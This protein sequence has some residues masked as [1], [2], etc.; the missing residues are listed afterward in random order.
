MMNEPVTRNASIGP[1][2]RHDRDEG[3]A[4][5]VPDHDHAR[6]RPLLWAVRM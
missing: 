5:H 6:P 3:V 1:E 4:D 2:D